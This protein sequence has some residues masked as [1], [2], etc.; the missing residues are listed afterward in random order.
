MVVQ[1]L[2]NT[3]SFG[4]LLLLAFVPMVQ[5]QDD[6]YVELD[7]CE[8][9]AFTIE[10]DFVP[11]NA[12]VVPDGIEYVS[13]GDLLGQDRVCARNWQLLEPLDLVGFGD[14]GL[15][16]VDILDYERGIV[17]F[18]VELDV[19]RDILSD[20]DLLITT[21]AIIPNRVFVEQF[22]VRH[23]VG[24][25]A[26]HFVGD[27]D[28][29]LEFVFEATEI[30]REDWSSNLM[31][32]L[33]EG[34][35]IDIWYSLEGTLGESPDLILDGDILSLRSMG[36]VIPQVALFPSGIPAGIPDRGVD[37]GAD[38]LTSSREIDRSAVLFSME[39]DH[40]TRIA[41]SDGDVLSLSGSVVLTN[42]DLLAIYEPEAGMGL[43]GLWSLDGIPPRPEYC[44]AI[45]FETAT[46]GQT[47]AN[48]D[49]YPEAGHTM[50]FVEFVFSNSTTFGGGEA[51]IDNM[52]LSGGTNQDLGLINIVGLFE[53]VPPA[54]QITLNYGAHG[55]SLNLTVNG[56]FL[57]FG[58]IT[59]LGGSLGGATISTSGTSTGI[60]TVT[61]T[62][63][64]FSIGGQELW[65][66]SICIER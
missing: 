9:L 44:I 17:A 52:N 27:P 65:I 54:T 45:E 63:E 42:A 5:A 10:E 33:L 6:V 49:S 1:R 58:D 62:I 14:M 56:D 12:D 43:D 55:G 47:F 29:I 8:E 34:Y 19:P 30:S 18:S 25:D 53:F 4:L 48:G 26:V 64:L 16:A 36:V 21:G 28:M 15:D 3:I 38:A 7:G 23:N 31:L 13:D 51:L 32:E 50:H 2:Y 57:N 60:L 40:E 37:F 11:R 22:D 66:D 61:G 24:L 46:L 39:L 59:T 41:A 35:D 20:G